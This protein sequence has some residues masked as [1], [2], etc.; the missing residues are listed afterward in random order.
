MRPI[1][2]SLQ[3]PPVLAYD[4]V[5]VD[6]FTFVH[7]SFWGLAP[8]TETW[9]GLGLSP[10]VA[11]M[12]RVKLGAWDPQPIIDS[13][14]HCSCALGDLDTSSYLLVRPILCKF[15]EGT[16]YLHNTVGTTD[17]ST[18]NKPY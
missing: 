2:T 5:S 9:V 1:H 6:P 4:L 17:D 15:L 14:L 13:Q 11:V 8:R 16:S 3:G 10:R 12:K 18:H 7:S